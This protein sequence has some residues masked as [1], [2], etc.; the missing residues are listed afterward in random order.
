MYYFAFYQGYCKRSKKCHNH[1]SRIYHATSQWVMRRNTQLSFLQ[2]KKESKSL[3]IKIMSITCTCR[4][5]M[6]PICCWSCTRMYYLNIQESFSIGEALL[7]QINLSLL[8]HFFQY[9]I[10]RRQN[11]LLINLISTHQKFLSIAPFIKR[12]KHNST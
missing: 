1:H 6:S 4:C 12:I 11:Q 8:E 9:R 2:H 10:S 7:F 3:I 5:H